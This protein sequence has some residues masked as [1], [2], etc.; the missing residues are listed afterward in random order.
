MI[1]QV[2][3]S[4]FYFDK[5][6]NPDR[7][8]TKGYLGYVIKISDA[9]E[10]FYETSIKTRTNSDMLD[11]HN[12]EWVHFMEFTLDIHKERGCKDLGNFNKFINGQIPAETAVGEDDMAIYREYER[13]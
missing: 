1:H 11:W 6:K 2:G 5:V 7:T 9:I 10:K 4:L 12:Q 3:D 13:Q 8:T